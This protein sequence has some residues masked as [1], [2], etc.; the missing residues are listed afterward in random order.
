[1]Y[2]YFM[3]RI[4]FLFFLSLTCFC[5]HNES[6]AQ[7]TVGTLNLADT[8][9]DSYTLF[10]PISTKKIYLIDNCGRIVNQWESEYFPGLSTY[11]HEDG[12][13]Y[14]AGKYS[15]SF[16]GAGLGGIIEIFNWDGDKIGSYIIA[17]EIKHQ[18]H[19]FHVLSSGNIL[20]ITWSI[21]EKAKLID[22]GLD[23]ESQLNEIVWLPKII[24][25]Q[26]TSETTYEII[27]EWNL[28]D[29]FVQ[30]LDESLPNYGSPSDFP[31]R[32]NINIYSEGQNADWF[33]INSIDYNPILDQIL[34]NSP[35]VHEFYIID[36]STTIEE[37][38][39]STGG[40]QGKG[41]DLLFRWGKPINYEIDKDQILFGQHQVQWIKSNDGRGNFTL[42]N[43]HEGQNS[44]DL[45]EVLEIENPVLED[46]SY[47]ITMEGYFPPEEEFWSISKDDGFEEYSTTLSGAQR[48]E[49][50][51][52]LVSIGEI[53]TI[54]EYD[55][56][57][58]LVWEYILP[59]NG[60]FPV[61]QG[62][63]ILNN[64]FFHS[65]KYPSNYSGFD[66]KNLEPG[67]YI[68]G[69]SEESLCEVLNNIIENPETFKIQ[70]PVQDYFQLP[71]VDLTINKIVV[72]NL[73]GKIIHEISPV[74]N[75]ISVDQLASGMYVFSFQSSNKTWVK[76][77][78]IL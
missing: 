48:L 1:M 75:E 46:G 18:H 7:I 62:S 53:G 71:E 19:D 56:N 29:H 59:F 65:T 55:E 28:S 68:E 60:I 12:K 26:P 17:D 47:P 15:G 74:S 50:G 2:F 43:N 24:E 37:A 45:S 64:S 6:F 3:I 9:D 25:I 14:R 54:M 4:L 32:I 61:D 67:E 66:G 70:N 51:H 42:F 11:L 58:T 57:K 30:N 72:F 38:A 22:L 20:A 13:L 76:K 41:G 27:W 73:Q 31:E 21:F 40:T 8:L 5:F 35:F 49:N 10:S 77:L 63:N 39:S 16:T 23:P 69:K 52:T 78:I 34:I 33:H 44:S 36:H